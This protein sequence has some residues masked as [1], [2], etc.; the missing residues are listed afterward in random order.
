[1]GIGND[2]GNGNANGKATTNGMK[3]NSDDTVEE[4]LNKL[5]GGKADKKK[6]CK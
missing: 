1:M 3:S 5:S 6:Q 4:Q 2:N